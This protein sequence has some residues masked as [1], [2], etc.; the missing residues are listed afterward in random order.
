MF[1]EFL[2]LSTILIE[3]YF[4]VKAFVSVKISKISAAMKRILWNAPICKNWQNSCAW[5]LSCKPSYRPKPKMRF[6][7]VTNLDENW[8]QVET[9]PTHTATAKLRW[10]FFCKTC[11]IEKHPRSRQVDSGVTIKT[12]SLRPKTLSQRQQPT[13][14]L[15]KL[16][17]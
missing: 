13:L 8:A 7:C 14:L 2:L 6:S 16:L 3:S 4:D 11:R 12:L 10:L 17:P 1:V 9:G 5:N 15:S